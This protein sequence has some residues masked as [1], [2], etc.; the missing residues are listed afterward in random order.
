M[1]L[2]PKIRPFKRGYLIFLS[3]ILALPLIFFFQNC[4]VQRP[5]VENAQF[6]SALYTHTGTEVSCSS[7]HEKQRPNSTAGFIGIDANT[8]FDYSTHASGVDCITCHDMS[9][10]NRVAADWANGVYGHASTLNMC[11][12]CH[13]TQR[14]ADHTSAVQQGDCFGCHQS[15]LNSSF[16]SMSDWQGG[17][18]GLGQNKWDASHDL[19]LPTEIPNYTGTT[20][21]SIQS[22]N[23]IAH[24][25]MNHSTSQLSTNTLSECSICHSNAS[26]GVYFPGLFHASITA[27]GIAQPT[28]CAD[29]HGT[30][31]LP[32]GFV[33]P[34]DTTRVTPQTA[35]M[36]HNAVVWSQ[37]SGVWSATSTPILTM[38]CATCHK[39]PGTS[40]SGGNFHSSLGNNQPSSCIDCHAN[41]RP[42]GSVM[43]SGATTSFDHSDAGL[44]DCISCHTSYVAWAPGKFHLSS[45][46]QS[47]CLSC[48]ASER[49]TS[50][51]GFTAYDNVNKPF[52]VTTHGGSL[53]CI[54]C[55][56]GTNQYVSKANWGTGN[57]SHVQTLSS[58]ISCHSSQRPTT[59][60]NGFNHSLSG[61][62]DCF[63][64]HKTSLTN[65]VFTSMSNWSGGQ[66]Q[67]TGLVGS[68]SISVTTTHLNY[69]GSKV[70][71]T[72]AS[73]LTL[74]LQILHSS[75]QVP[76]SIQNNCATCHSGYPSAYAGGKF[77]S[78]LTSNS[79]AQPT[80]CT[81]CHTA[82]MPTDIVHNTSDTS[83]LKPMDHA[84]GFTSGGTVASTMNC[85]TC[86]LNPGVSF[87][88]A[89]FHTNIGT[90]TPSNCTTCHYQV[91]PT[92]S[93]NIMLHTSQFA[94]SLDCKTCHSLPTASQISSPALSSWSGGLFHS[95]ISNQPT[96][97]IDCHTSEKPAVVTISNVD[98][99]HMNHMSS[100]VFAD[101]A[102]C[103]KNDLTI[104]P[105]AWQKIDL[106]HAAASPTTCKECHGLGNGST[107][108]GV[109]NDMPSGMTSSGTT[110]TS[111]VA[112]ANTY[113]QLTHN[114]TEVTSRDCNQCHTNVGSTGAKWKAASFHA[115]I[116]VISTRCDTC[117]TNIKPSVVV[118]GMDHSTIGTQD[119]KTCH[120]FPG[121]GVLGSST[122]PPNWKGASG[123]V[124]T[125]IT[126]LAPTTTT[127]SALTLAHPSTTSR[128]GMT[129]TTCHLNYNSTA[130][131]IG[132]D[133]NA[134]PTGAKCVYCH[135][136]GQQVVSAANVTGFTTV[137]TTHHSAKFNSGD[138]CNSCHN[139]ALPTYSN[140]TFKFSGGQF[141]P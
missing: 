139:N 28:A 38:D 112:A 53:D 41:S 107:S 32:I 50:T 20:I 97:C 17:V 140:T 80:S 131:I 27:A 79:L 35:E 96:A 88:G 82:T 59:V 75:T 9:Q 30:Q 104:T 76:S 110:T 86:H 137:S 113:D 66:S 21:S 81:D 8:P 117:H 126:L 94:S 102:S 121:T 42:N 33:G 60:V 1:G 101:C 44:G 106:F 67:P 72:T 70:S 83:I 128:T 91:M 103:H 36:K 123:A 120:T 45:G 129:C 15:A 51:S 54:T 100:N 116:S 93:V 125:S 39:N 40:W 90:K 119:C 5:S 77:H 132:F 64:C 58:C 10:L 141:N 25:Q 95:N 62:G 47:S 99:Q 46:A 118:S 71:S 61:T 13:S 23:Q 114:V 37:T 89:G 73:A 31:T 138:D 111:S 2:G 74:P 133:H 65:G 57:Y 49:P 108:V 18:G 105:L 63:G 24:M 55:H 92:T 135:L 14:P 124:P 84:A 115:N 109:N 85:A 12:T 48:H 34:I 68:L 7:C 56:S 122:N 43:A 16:S 69:T 130:S 29:C 136:Q 22:Q 52:D 87:S 26:S 3:F 19:T 4:G 134:M 98:T 78:S 11:V 127:L 6:A